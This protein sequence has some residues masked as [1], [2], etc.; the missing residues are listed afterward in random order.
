MLDKIYDL[1]LVI[2]FLFK[3][4]KLLLEYC[5]DVNPCLNDGLCSST[6]AEYICEC[7]YGFGG[8]NCE[9]G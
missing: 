9:T 5:K 4:F 8:P 1:Y 6:E 2:V 3:T 7:K